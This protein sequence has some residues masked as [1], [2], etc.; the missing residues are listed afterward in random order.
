MIRRTSRLAEKILNLKK[1]RLQKKDP[2]V[3]FLL[4]IFF[5]LLWM[6]TQ[7]HKA[8]TPYDAIMGGTGIE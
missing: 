1:K 4:S 7:F 2:V 5:R 3:N 8:E 6:R